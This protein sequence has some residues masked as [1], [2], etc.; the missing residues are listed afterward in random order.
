MFNSRIASKID[1]INSRLDVIV[2][3]QNDFNLNLHDG[4][5]GTSNRSERRMPTTSLV[6]PHVYGRYQDRE[7]ILKM[8]FE[9]RETVP[10]NVSVIPIVGLDGIGKTTLAQLVYNDETV[11]EFFSLKA[12]VCVSEEFDVTTVTKTIFEAV[13]QTS[14]ES[15]DLNTL[16]VT[17]QERLSKEKFLLILD[18]VWNEEYH[19]WDL[20]RRP[21]LVGLTRSKIIVTT[22]HITVANM[23][24]SKSI[25]PYVMN[26]LKAR[27][28]LSLLAQHALG[29]RDFDAHPNL[30]ELGEKL[31]DKCGGLPLAT[32]ALGGI[33]RSKM[34][35][36]EWEDVLSSK[37]WDL[38]KEAKILPVLRLSYYH[39]PSHLKQL[40]AYCSIFPKD[41]E[42]DRYELVLLWMGEGFLHQPNGRKTIEEF[43]FECFK[44]LESRSFFQCVSRSDSCFVMH[45]LI[46]DLAQFVAGG[47][48]RRL[49]DK[50]RMCILQCLRVLSLSGYSISELP[51]SICS[52]IHLRY[53]NLS[54]T[55]ITSLP[56]TLGNLYNLQSLSL[57]NCRI[58]T[59][60]PET[61]GDLVNLRHLDNAN[62][63]QLKEMPVGIGKLES[64]QTLPK[65]VVGEYG[66]LCLSELKNLTLLQGVVSIVELHN[67]ASIQ[68]AKEANLEQKTGLSEV[69]LIWSDSRGDSRD[70]ILEFTVLEKLQPH[71]NLQTLKVDYFG[72]MKF[73][74]WI[75]DPLFLKLDSISLTN[76]AKC[77]S[78]PPLGQLP[79]L[80]HLRIGGMPGVKR[81]GDE[82][83]MFN[84]PLE[85]PFP[86]LETLRF[87]CMP[88]WEEWFCG[89]GYQKLEF[90]FPHLHQLTMYKCQKLERVSSLSLPLLHGLD[91]QE[92]NKGILNSFNHMTSLTYLKVE[93]VTGLSCLSREFMQYAQKLEALEICNCEEMIVLWGNGLSTQSLTCLKRLVIADCTSIVSLGNV[94]QPLPTN[95]E[96]LEI[97]RCAS[98]NSLPVELNTGIPP[99]LRR[100]EIQGCNALN[101]LPNGLS[102]LER[103]ELRDCSSLRA[104][105]AE[106][107]PS[108]FKKI[109]IKNVEHLDSV[110]EESFEPNKVMSLEELHVSNWENVGT[111]LQCIHRFSLLAELYVSQ[112]ETLESFP[113]Q[114]LPTPN[115][116]ILS[117]EYCPQLKSTPSQIH[118][119]SSLVSLEIRSC[120]KL[121]TFPKGDLPSS[122]TSLRIWDSRKLKPLPEWQL[123]RLTSRFSLARFPSLKY[124]SKVLDTLTSLQH[125]SVMNCPKLQTLPCKGILDG[126]WHLEISNCKE[127]KGRCMKDKG[128][129]WQMIADIP[130]VEI[131]DSMF[132]AFALLALLQ[133]WPEAT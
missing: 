28:C 131:D 123:D 81:I 5:G 7:E 72:G 76:C 63:D 70:E 54:G 8:V 82:F 73:P 117:I 6:E 118:R 17:L 59:K 57:R 21:F 92:C 25:L 56:E 33:L 64:L 10:D 13:T 91:L 89:T 1:D 47:M 9:S 46:N 102:N 100:L 40:F 23:V 24:R 103:L 38:P 78:L 90:Q 99:M 49:D 74:T 32:K 16:Q 133:W 132:G 53:L 12:W 37:L 77:T 19:S 26:T 97:F 87:E 69:Q 71:R 67:V 120:P 3:Q 42:F 20:L 30:K 129:Y 58:I 15:K 121:E 125:L 110:S 34:S 112:C 128:E 114:G 84:Y 104:W 43:G 22:R 35:P 80:K 27:E 51:S 61:L 55:A 44:E 50:C 113:E 60:L 68:E 109:V 98:L 115:L 107:F 11:K 29:E 127:L 62:T 2:K 75:G 94:D 4:N 83:F 66:G 95:L 126:L 45:D 111:L 130:C 48:C 93:S 36:S 119:I 85:R 122:L 52:L 79:K 39:L 106:N 105:S 14:G 116:R 86:C 124:L 31:A 96:V 41:Y 101:S 88:E 108:T 18:D 65:I